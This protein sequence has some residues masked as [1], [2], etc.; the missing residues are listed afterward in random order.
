MIQDV[1]LKRCICDHICQFRY[2]PGCSNQPNQSWSRNATAFI[3]ILNPD[4]NCWLV[5][6]ELI[7][8]LSLPF[9]YF[10]PSRIDD[11]IFNLPRPIKRRSGKAQSFFNSS[12]E[13]LS[14]L[15]WRCNFGVSAFPVPISSLRIWLFQVSIVIICTNFSHIFHLETLASTCR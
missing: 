13:A 8:S 14:E 7:P 15:C 1:I 3:M 6:F 2:K 5:K 11:E 9:S 10:R 12:K 4:L